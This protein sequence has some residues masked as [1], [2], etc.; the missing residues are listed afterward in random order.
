MLHSNAN[1]PFLGYYIDFFLA[2]RHAVARKGSF[3]L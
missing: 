3:L 1:R 2:L